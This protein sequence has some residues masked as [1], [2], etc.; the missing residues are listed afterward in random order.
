MRSEVAKRPPSRGTSGLRSGGRIGSTSRIIHSGLLPELIN[1]SINLRRFIFLLFFACDFVTLIS[2]ERSSYA[3]SKFI[4]SRSSLIASAPMPTLISFPYSSIALLYISSF[5]RV[6]VSYGVRPPSTTINASK[7]NTFS[8]CLKVIS[9]IKPILDGND[10]RNQI[11]ATGAA[12]S[13]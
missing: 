10:L 8:I 11:C 13:I 6:P 7:Y 2:S 3:F 1:D 9:I 12:N 5:N 4:L